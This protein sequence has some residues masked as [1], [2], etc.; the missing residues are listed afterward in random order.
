[1]RSISDL[2]NIFICQ[3]FKS[4]SSDYNNLFLVCDII[5]SIQ[6][7]DIFLSKREDSFI[8]FIFTNFSPLYKQEDHKQKEI[9]TQ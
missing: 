9:H 7:R 8:M 5:L 3:A 1:M 6:A 2:R 4:D